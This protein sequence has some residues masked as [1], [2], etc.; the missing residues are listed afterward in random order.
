MGGGRSPRDRAAV[1]PGLP[2]ARFRQTAEQTLDALLDAEAE[3]LGGA[4][5]YEHSAERLDTRAGHFNRKLQT[6]ASEV[7]LRASSGRA[8]SGKFFMVPSSLAGCHEKL[9]KLPMLP[10]KTASEIGIS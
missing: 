4:K 7:T 5:R 3:E 8:S 1:R 6:K 9:V 10:V 2:I